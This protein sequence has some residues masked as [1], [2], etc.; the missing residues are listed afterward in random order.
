ME[1]KEKFSVVEEIVP[2][3]PQCKKRFTFQLKQAKRRL[4]FT[5]LISNDR[6]KLRTDLLKF[7]ILLLLAKR[8]FLFCVDSSASFSSVRAAMKRR[9][10]R[11]SNL[12]CRFQRQFRAA[13]ATMK[14]CKKLKKL[15]ELPDCV[16]SHIFSMLSLK[17]LVKTSALSKQWI[18]EWGLRTDLNFDLHNMF[19]YNTIQDLPQKTLLLFPII[20]RLHFQSEFATRL[21]QFMLHY[22]GPVIRSIRIDF[23]LGD[24]HTDVIDRLISKGI[25]KGVK[26]IELLFSFETEEVNEFK[27]LFPLLPYKFSFALLSD[28][29]SLTYLHLRNCFLAESAD[30]SGLKNLTT[31]VVEGLVETYSTH[32]LSLL[33]SECL[34][35]EAATF[36]N[37][38]IMWPMKITGPKLRHLNII[39]CFHWSH[40][41]NRIVIDALNLSSFEYSCNITRKI[42]VMAPRLLKVFW[43]AVVRE[44]DRLPFSTIAK[45]T[46]I[47]NLAMIISPSQIE[48]LTK[49]LVRFQKLRQLELFIEGAYDLLDNMDLF[50][51]LDIAMAS[52][53]LHKFVGTKWV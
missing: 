15:I 29:D 51:I 6:L 39:N 48:K 13:T 28:T 8:R 12:L 43:N 25:A 17:D 38:K 34:Q 18:H 40:S 46:H 3:S 2:L 47:E 4:P 23:P 42:S 35:I 1:L 19:D 27:L 24:D 41:P 45:L 33:F 32:I 26:R 16:M 31:I 44:E 50:W 11:S 30:F 9:K 22:Q 52:Q 20:Q 53:H 10:N 14:R 5:I 49:K 36:K 21:D 7:R 37:C